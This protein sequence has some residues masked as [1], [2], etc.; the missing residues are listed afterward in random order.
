M[1][2]YRIKDWNKVFEDYRSRE[3]AELEFIKWPTKRAS[4]AF[5]KLARSS[6]GVMAFGVFAILVQWAARCPQRGVLADTKGAITPE[7]F[8]DRYGLPIKVAKKAFAILTD[9]DCGWLE[10]TDAAPTNHRRD[11]DDASVEVTDEPPTPHRQDT[12]EAPSDHR[13]YATK[14]QEP[15]TTTAAAATNTAPMTPTGGAAP[16]AADDAIRRWAE[17]QAKRPDWLPS[18]KPWV[19][20][21]SW[22]MIAHANPNLTAEQFAA[23]IREARQSRETLKSPAAFILSQIRK[24]GGVA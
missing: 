16:A 22:L 10:S 9:I 11:T 19:S 18:G 23:I 20:A 24:I 21:A 8:A 3:V 7:R 4:E 12:D 2:V 14:N 1:Q 17:E 13:P 5:H 15:R 6:D